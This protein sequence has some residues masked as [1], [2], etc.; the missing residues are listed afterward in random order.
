MTETSPEERSSASGASEVPRPCPVCGSIMNMTQV[1]GVT[2]DT[3]E[4]HGIWLDRGE[5][6]LIAL[7]HKA[8]GLKNRMRRQK[9]LRNDG[10]EDVSLLWVL[11]QLFK[12]RPR[13]FKVRPK[14]TRSRKDPKDPAKDPARE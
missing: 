8:K 14:V 2:V 3:C 9:E 6:E 5:L 11:G 13:V 1:E 12:G 4:E 10:P 7:K